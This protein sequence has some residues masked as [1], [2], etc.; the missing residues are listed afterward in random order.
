MDSLNAFQMLKEDLFRFYP[1][2]SQIKKD[3]QEV[4]FKDH[5]LDRTNPFGIILLQRSKYQDAE[6]FYE[7]CLNM[8]S[9]FENKNGISL[10]KGM[11]LG[12]LGVAQIALGKTDQGVAN[13]IAAK[14][15]DQDYISGP[16]SLKSFEMYQ[17]F[18]RKTLEEMCF[19]CGGFPKAEIESAKRYLEKLDSKLENRLFQFSI[20]SRI[21]ENLRVFNNNKTNPYPKAILF[22]TV[23]DQCLLIEQILRDNGVSGKYF[24]DLLKNSKLIPDSNGCRQD[25]ENDFDSNLIAILKISD[26]LERAFKLALCVRNFNNHRFLLGC[27]EFFNNLNI[28]I[29]TIILKCPIFLEQKGFI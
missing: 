9:D 15:D 21:R 26:D 27:V 29:E 8:I 3:S 14:M 7:Q 23:R 22:A 4:Q 1:L 13:L 12:N 16:I 24:S 2:C 19:L 11:P 28:I 17:Q 18:E 10:A 25:N 6:V 5:Y 20:L